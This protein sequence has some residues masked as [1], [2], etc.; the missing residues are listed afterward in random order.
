M[1]CPRCGFQRSF[2][3]AEFNT[4]CADCQW[5]QMQHRKP[6]LIQK[7][8]LLRLYV[9]KLIVREQERRALDSSCL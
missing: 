8:I 4:V 9:L 2:W 7:F 6:W 5:K 3:E 1:H